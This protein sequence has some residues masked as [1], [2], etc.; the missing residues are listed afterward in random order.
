MTVS[1][2]LAPRRGLAVPQAV[3]TLAWGV[4][5]HTGPGGEVHESLAEAELIDPFT[6]RPDLQAV[7]ATE[8]HGPDF[9]GDLLVISR[10]VTYA[11]GGLGDVTD[12]VAPP[13]EAETA[14]VHAALDYL[15]YTGP[16]QVRLLLTVDG[17][18]L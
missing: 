5:L 12:K 11:D 17:T 1:S 14:A 9:T 13:T 3:V 10:T 7:V 8:Q 15:G 6:G 18:T 16:R 4:D 2:R